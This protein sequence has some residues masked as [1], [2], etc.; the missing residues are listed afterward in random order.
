MA[1]TFTFGDHASM[2]AW[3]DA[4]TPFADFVRRRERSTLTYELFAA[5]DNP[6]QL[7]VFERWVD[8]RQ[9]NVGKGSRPPAG[10]GL[11]LGEGRDR[12]GRQHGASARPCVGHSTWA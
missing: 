2:D 12:C 7:M 4:W 6:L 11:R 1:V 8:A 9:L 3:R 5:K 10:L